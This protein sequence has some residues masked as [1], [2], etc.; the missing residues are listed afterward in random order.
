VGGTLTAAGFTIEA[1]ETMY[2]PGTP[3]IAGW[4]EWGAARP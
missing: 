1:I 4:N 3:K 2:L